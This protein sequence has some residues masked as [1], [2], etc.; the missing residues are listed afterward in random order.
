MEEKQKYPL[1]QLVT[2]KQKRL[3]EAEKVL[4][5]KKQA[6][7]KEQDKLSALEKE[8]DE[9]KAHKIAKLTQLRAKMDEGVSAPKIQQMKQYLKI[10][11][12]KLK[13]HDHKVQEQEKVVAAA[14]KQVEA[15]REELFKKQ[16]DVEKL[17]MHHEEW[18]ADMAKIQEQKEA[19]DTDEMGGAMH[20]IKKRAKK[21]KKHNNHG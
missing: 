9:V 18:N 7:E 17:K 11:D 12:E 21:H 6:L 2:I 14:E 15:A 4:L 16:K 19:A 20:I 10:V 5:E 13:I 3:E 8:R 1:E